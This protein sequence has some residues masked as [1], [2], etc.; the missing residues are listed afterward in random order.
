MLNQNGK[1]K[2]RAHETKT[3]QKN[4]EIEVRVAKLLE[5]LE[6]IEVE[7]PWM[8]TWRTHKSQRNKP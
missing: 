2:K 3:E 6:Q 1:Q 4:E 5:N 8:K 7:E